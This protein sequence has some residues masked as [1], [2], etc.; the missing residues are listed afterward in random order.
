M[1]ERYSAVTKQDVWAF[2]EILGESHV[3]F[4]DFDRLAPYRSDE[5]GEHHARDPEA[6]VKPQTTDDISRVVAYCNKRRI[7][8]TA[9]GA[10]SGLSGGAVPLFGGVVLSFERMSKILEI[11]AE[12]MVAVAEPGVVTND[13]CRR[14]AEE[15]LFYAGYPMSV[16]SSFIGGNVAC[17]A[18]GAKVIKYGSTAAH[19]LGLDVVLASGEILHLGGKRRKDSS[20]YSLLRMMVGSEGTLGLF[21]KIYLRLIPQPGP[22]AD[23]LVSF[24]S[25]EDAISAVPGAILAS[26]GMPAAVEF[27][28][29]PTMRYAMDY[30][31]SSVVPIGEA[32]AYLIIQIEASTRNTLLDAY[33]PVGEACMDR[34]ALEV[35]VADNRWASEKIW[36]IRRNCLEALRAIDPTM[37][38]GDFVVPSTEMSAMMAFIR[39]LS[40]NYRAEIPCSG[41]VADGNIHPHPLK[42][43]DRSIEEWAIQRQ[44]LLGE[45]ALKAVELGGAVSG[46]HGIGFLKND[47][48]AQSKR[49][50][51][52]VMKAIKD[53]LDPNGILNPGKLFSYEDMAD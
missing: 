48:L 19:V 10:G 42:P 53:A 23:L 37:E 15:G 52:R 5:S 51:L 11:D 49:D 41:H 26:V 2:R 32:E 27:I 14:V 38:G 45:I 12:N 7:P 9:R 3:V 22:S 31:G 46:E 33:R 28:D 36:A 6:V 17:N 35:L 47:L 16:E 43:E 4:D 30:V 20:G 44:E 40:L 50:E 29:K 39:E 8:V 13:L 18:G 24:R 25:I 1:G 21:T 34:G